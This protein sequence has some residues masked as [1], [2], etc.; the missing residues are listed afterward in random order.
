MRQLV[1]CLQALSLIVLAFAVLDAPGLYAQVDTGTITGTVTDPSGAVVPGATVDLINQETNFK[2]TATTD[3]SGS[4]TFTPIKIGT[5]TVEASFR[6]FQQAVH[7]DVS[8]QV[9][10]NVNVSFAL[11]TGS[12]TQTVQVTA[13]P[14]LLETASASVG[15]VVG[16]RQV[17]NLPLNG[18]NY[19]FL[20][21]ISA[22]VVSGG[23][24]GRGLDANGTFSANGVRP[25]QNNYLL[26][27][28]D[29]NADLVDFL[30]STSYVVLPPVDAIQEFKV[31]TTDFSAQF[32]RAGG[33]ILNATSK[34]GANAYHGDAWEFLRNSGLDAR[35]FFET[36]KG[37]YRQNQFGATFGGPLTIPHVY[38]GKNKTWFFLD[39]EGT[40]VRQAQPY[41]STVPTV[42]ERSSGFKDFSELIAGQ[43]GTQ[44]DANGTLWP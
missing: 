37:E 18:R 40:R 36:S 13:A 38:N 44:K 11:Q 25:A 20:A 28:M 7:K 6:G 1:K 23:Q 4:Y 39:Y 5:Y 10:A 16:Q 24:E 32:G 14:P 29:D 12:V 42:E 41:V 3:S 21:Q 2:L 43:S 22:G 35:N 33:A 15:Q 31:Q 8:V 30:N 9:Q 34:S 27:G 17:N 19:T 26:D